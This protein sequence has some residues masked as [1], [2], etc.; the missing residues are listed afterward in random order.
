MITEDWFVEETTLKMVSSSSSHRLSLSHK[1]ML[2]QWLNLRRVRELRDGM[3]SGRF[4]G[5][6]L[7]IEPDLIQ[8][9]LE[10]GS[11]AVRR[12]VHFK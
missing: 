11:T 7:G 4:F 2:G 1:F 6:E 10:L 8:V 5:F 12:S 3:V 9:Q